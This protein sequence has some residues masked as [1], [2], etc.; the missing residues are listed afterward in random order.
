MKYIFE[1][2]FSTIL[3]II[4]LTVLSTWTLLSLRKEPK[5]IIKIATQEQAE[6]C[7]KL[8]GELFWPELYNAFNPNN[9]GMGC[10]KESETYI[11]N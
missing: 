9:V 1:S 6:K 7:K 2:L 5:P 10:F 4:V 11:L 8:G 3:V